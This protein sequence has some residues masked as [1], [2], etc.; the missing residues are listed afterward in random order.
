VEFDVLRRTAARADAWGR[1]VHAAA[2]WRATRR[3]ERR[4]TRDV[5]VLFATS[6]RDRD[7]FERE[8]GV[9]HVTVVPNGID[10]TE[11]AP[12]SGGGQAA[13]ILFSGLMSYYPNQQAV[14]WFLDEVFPAVLRRV[15]TATL[16]VAGAAP[17]RWL[18]A[19]A[20]ERVRVTGPVPDMRPYL[21]EARAFVAP[22]WI[23]G[24]TRVKILEALAVGRAVVSTTVGA[25]GLEA[26]HGESILLADDASEFARHLVN[27]LTDAP[28]ARALAEEGRRHVARHFDWDAIGRTIRDELQQRVGLVPARAG[29][30]G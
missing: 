7:I 21:E 1:R 29:A 5:A 4:S 18:L 27:V 10:L 13:T 11:F 6:V 16:V 15:P 28:L 8:L 19:R 26:R 9:S 25:E 23:G 2:Q 12:A 30:P 14:R 24:G 17:P 3:E 22:L 20:C